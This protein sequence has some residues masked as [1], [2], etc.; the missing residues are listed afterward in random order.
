MTGFPD[1]SY[2][3]GFW[4]LPDTPD[5]RHPLQDQLI[6]FER[7][8]IWNL[9]DLFIHWKNFALATCR[10]PLPSWPFQIQPFLAHFTRNTP[11]LVSAVMLIFHI[12]LDYR[13]L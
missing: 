7:K 11:F 5:P 12:L 3:S 1:S 6:Q 4:E 2:V 9:S 10:L 13:N 8:E